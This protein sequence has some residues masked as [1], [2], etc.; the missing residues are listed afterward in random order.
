M[1]K[2]PVYCAESGE[3][4]VSVR[5]NGTGNAAEGEEATSSADATAVPAQRS[6]QRILFAP[7][8]GA[9][10]CIRAAGAGPRGG[11]DAPR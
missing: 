10:R 7:Y 11:R 9:C 1:V 2:V 8:H 4:S 3:V 5:A 6:I